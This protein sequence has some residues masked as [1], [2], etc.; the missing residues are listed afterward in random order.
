M[1]ASCLSSQV[2]FVD[3]T[4]SLVL[5]PAKFN[6]KLWIGKGSYLIVEQNRSS[7]DKDRITGSIDRVLHEGDV[8]ELMKQGLW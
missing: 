4:S 8:K 1:P 7:T 2:Y 3:G 5:L 6:K